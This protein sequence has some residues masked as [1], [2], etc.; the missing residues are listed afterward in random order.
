VHVNA[1][2]AAI[3]AALVM[4][5]RKGFPATPM[6]PHNLPATVTGA[7]MLW[8]G[9]FGF[10]A[11]SALAADGAAGMAMLVTHIGAAAG[12]L[13]WMSQ[14]WIK[15]G[16]PSVL[17][18]VT[19][20]V[21]GLGTITPASGFVGPGG[22]LIIGILAGFVCFWATQT[23]KRRLQID[24]SLDVF[25][26]HGV[27]GFIGLL[28]TA[29]FASDGLGAFSG[30]GLADGQTVGG[31][32]LVQVLGASATVVWCGVVTFVLLKIIGAGI[33]LRVTDEEETEG[34]D[35]VLHEERGYNL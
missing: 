17:G 11:G 13:A 7:C 26:V 15:F 14:E 3:V 27:G 5:N 18:I 34:L 19:G 8:V 28:L 22:A 30:L 20:M 6:P 21:A 25:P 29:V 12:S 31:Q 2:V 4:G 9:W 35:L 33:G 1:G 16:K 23:V 32:L 10:N 24:D